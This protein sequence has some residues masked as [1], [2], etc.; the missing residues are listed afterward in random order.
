MKTDQQ[1]REEAEITRELASH[2]LGELMSAQHL[3]DASINPFTAQYIRKAIQFLEGS[4]NYGMISDEART[5]L[6]TQL[7]ESQNEDPF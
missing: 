5:V 6:V 7:R 1:I 3:V 2:A 4:L